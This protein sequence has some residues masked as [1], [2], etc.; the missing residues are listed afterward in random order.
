MTSWAPSRFAGLAPSLVLTAFLALAG[1]ATGPSQPPAPISTGQPRVEPERE[2]VDRGDERR[3]SVH[4]SAILADVNGMP[5]PKP[6][7]F[8]PEYL[9]GRD[10]VRAGVLLPF[11]HP[12]AN[13]RAEAEGMLA[14][15]EMALFDHA[16][17]EFVLLPKDTA[18]SQSVA[19]EVAHE[20]QREGAEFFLGPLFGSNVA[21]LNTDMALAGMPIVGFSNDRTVAGGSTWLA[22]ITPEEE[23]RT[24]VE[25]AVSRGIRQFAYFG[26]QSDIGSRIQSAL[27][28]HV[29]MAGG[30][31]VSS[32]Y[33]PAGEGSPTSEAQYLAKSINQASANGRVAVLI[34]ER[35]TQ[36][37]RVAP[38]L[39]YYGVS[40]SVKLMGLSG[41][42]DPGIWREPSLSEGWFVAP[43]QADL[44]A[45]ESRYR[46]IYGQAP[47]S[48]ASQAYDAAALAMQLAK[49]GELDREELT[50]RDGFYGLNGLF[51]FAPDGTSERQ[52]AI[53]EISS[54]G[55]EEIQPAGQSFE[56]DIG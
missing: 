19:V 41:W 48:L 50:E 38:L 27:Q 9:Q 29:Q 12:N 30:S 55:A 51:R 40:R 4:D 44:Q 32:A 6:G 49:D 36:L 10:I 46:R 26:P 3:G 28:F 24:L 35:G 56:P 45:F 42:N 52:L 21:V 20:A 37:R 39:A 16:D 11:S 2:T 22:S 17:Q 25:Y 18:G 8:T 43:P 13:V 7:R 5:L 53:Y 23:V 47:S 33:Y 34:P 14:G 54:E 1:C 15:I 31:L